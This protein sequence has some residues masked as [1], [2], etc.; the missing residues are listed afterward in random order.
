MNSVTPVDL[1]SM[2]G[3]RWRRIQALFHEAVD[4]PA[5]TRHSYLLG[6]CGG[7]AGLVTEVLDLIAEDARGSSLLDRD[8]AQTANR[9]LGNDPAALRE[10]GPYRIVSVLGEGGMGVVFLAERT[11]LGSRA[12]IKILRDA[13]LSPARRLRFAAEQRTLAALNHP[14]IARL[15]DAG[16]LADG[17]PWIVMEYVDGVPLN[18]YCRAHAASGRSARRCRARRGTRASR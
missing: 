1:S 10:I 6:A 5:A 13:W 12:A 9:L 8:V 4:R 7:D 3:E 14:S 18:E 15:H 2:D 16:T 11:D 17:T